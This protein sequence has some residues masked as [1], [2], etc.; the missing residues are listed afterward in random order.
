M[1]AYN[2]WS[3]DRF[4]TIGRALLGVKCSRGSV[5]QLRWLKL[6]TLSGSDVWTQ[7][8]VPIRKSLCFR[9][10]GTRWERVLPLLLF[11]P[12][13]RVALEIK[14]DLLQAECGRPEQ[15]IKLAALVFLVLHDE[16]VLLTEIRFAK[17]RCR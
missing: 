9:I 16:G 3:R 8:F 1:S 6:R 10:G 2:P 11:F 15:S 4:S 13:Q 17:I 7:Q 5:L 12:R 14:R